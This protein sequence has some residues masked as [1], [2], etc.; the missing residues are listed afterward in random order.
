M[1]IAIDAMGGDFAPKEIVLGCLHAAKDYQDTHFMLYGHEDEIRQFFQDQDLDN[2]EI[3]H[4]TAKVESNDDPVRAVRR[5]KDASM[6]MAAQ[7]VKDG[8]ADA[9]FSCGNTGALVASGL[10][11]IGRINQIDRPALM[12]TLPSF[13]GQA[14]AS[15]ILDLGANADAKPINVLQHALMASIYA[16]DIRG[17]EKPTV[18][19]L[20]IGTEE[21]KGNDLM[22]K[23]YDLLAK[24]P[25]LNFYGNIEARDL[26]N[27]VV[28]IIVADGFTGNAVLKTMEGTALTLVS[29]IKDTI[30]QG[31]LK[32]KVGG[33]MI[34]DAL[35]TMAKQVDYNQV[36]GA[37]L[38]GV[39]APVMKSHGSSKAEVVHYC[40]TNCRNILKANMV[41]HLIERFSDDI[42]PI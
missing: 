30:L 33:W 1:R 26:L 13:S 2:I 6:V 35:K 31:N 3:I 7:A 14:Q 23:S 21:N 9:L 11:V 24:D 37:L 22:K 27:G 18:G 12:T 28:D 25:N 39:Q 42:N 19:L 5:K 38:I 16:E 34:K 8:Q 17:I 20:N 41:S 15:D 29:A 32:T 10:L 40:L 4:T 36:G